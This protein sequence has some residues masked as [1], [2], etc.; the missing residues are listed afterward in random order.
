M[1]LSS[2]LR[3]SHCAS[4]SCSS[5]WMLWRRTRY[6]VSQWPSTMIDRR[7]T[8]F[9]PCLYVVEFAGD[10]AGVV[11]HEFRL[12]EEIALEAAGEDG[13]DRHRDTVGG[14]DVVR[15]VAD[16]EGELRIASGALERGF[17][18]LRRRLRE[19]RVAL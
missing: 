10:L 11:Q 14:E 8:S 19:L 4:G 16:G 6:G 2:R 18:D 7:W 1:P 13:D 12:G 9:K 5:T 15:S 3:R 17:E